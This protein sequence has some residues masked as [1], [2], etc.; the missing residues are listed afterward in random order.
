MKNMI[1]MI[2]ITALVA[3]IGFSTAAC[4]NGNGGGDNGG[5][6]NPGLS[7]EIDSAL[8]GTWRD[9]LTGD[10][11]TV[12]FSSSGITCGGTAGSALNDITSAYSGPG[13]T[14]VWVAGNGNISYKYS[15]MGGQAATLPVYQ[16]RTE[17]GNLILSS[18]GTDFVTMT[19]N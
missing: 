7:N 13:Y 8:Y 1:K 15:Y 4:D 5:G 11:L 17:G 6:N 16:Y 12:T 9:T 2:G 19:R 18:E 14:L 10:I 3:V